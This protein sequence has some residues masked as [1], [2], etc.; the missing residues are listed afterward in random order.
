MTVCIQPRKEA[1]MRWRELVPSQTAGGVEIAEIL[2]EILEEDASRPSSRVVSPL[3]FV[4]RVGLRFGTVTKYPIQNE[5]V[6]H[7][8][9]LCKLDS[10]PF[11]SRKFKGC[12]QLTKYF[13][14]QGQSG[15]QNSFFQYIPPMCYPGFNPQFPTEQA[16]L[17][18]YKPYILN[19]CKTQHWFLFEA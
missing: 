3:S 11:G 9:T 6:V 8:H 14:R 7:W 5:S 18:V 10:V 17:T 16:P 19:R 2:K 1:F 12:L 13:H 4:R 15:G